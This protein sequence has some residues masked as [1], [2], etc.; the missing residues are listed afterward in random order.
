MAPKR[1]W[2]RTGFVIRGAGFDSLRGLHSDA[3]GDPLTVG[4]LGS[5]QAGRPSVAEGTPV[6]VRPR[7]RDVK[8]ACQASTLTVRVRLPSLA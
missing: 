8:A 2:W 7:E 4:L 6:K 5:A 3:G 1:R